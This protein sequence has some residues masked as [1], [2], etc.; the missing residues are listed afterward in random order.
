ML[1]PWYVTGFADGEAAF[2]YSRAGGSF[3]IYFSI[4]QRED[5][6]QLVEEIYHFFGSIGQIYQNPMLILE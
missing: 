6:R 5:N 1:N 4:K 3:G 2:T